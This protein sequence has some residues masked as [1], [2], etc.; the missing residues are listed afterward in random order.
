MSDP[1]F[2]SC[3]CP[4]SA[5]RYTR[6][7]WTP[8]WFSLLWKL[9]QTEIALIFTLTLCRCSTTSPS[10]GSTTSSSTLMLCTCSRM[11]PLQW[12]RVLFSVYCFCLLVSSFV[13]F[14]WYS[15][16]QSTSALLRKLNPYLTPIFNRCSIYHGHVDIHIYNDIW[17]SLQ[18]G[19][20]VTFEVSFAEPLR[21][22]SFANQVLNVLLFQFRSGEGRADRIMC[23]YK[24]VPVSIFIHT[25]SCSDDL[26]MEGL[27]L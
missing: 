4:V 26:L 1:V 11:Y 21:T 9:G 27:L 8:G 16:Y 25:C 19:D 13:L 18:P 3:A 6:N 14:A 5:L 24:S 2:Y 15:L 7:S 22:L 17:M 10:T 12:L 23:C 20:S